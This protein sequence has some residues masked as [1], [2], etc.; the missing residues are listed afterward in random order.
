MDVRGAGPPGRTL[1][2]RGKMLD[3][4]DNLDTVAEI[5][6]EYKDERRD[7]IEMAER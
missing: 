3:E 4:D 1:T 7:R 6:R 5:N 2:R